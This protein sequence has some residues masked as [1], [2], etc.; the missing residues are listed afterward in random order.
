MTYGSGSPKPEAGPVIGLT[1]PILIVPLWV[2]EV[3]VRQAS[4]NPGAARPPR[5]RPVPLSMSRRVIAPGPNFLLLTCSS[6]SDQ[7]NAPCT[8]DRQFEPSRSKN[9]GLILFRVTLPSGPPP[10]SR[11]PQARR[12]RSG[13]AG[14][15]APC[16]DDRGLRESIIH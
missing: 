16:T 15:I 9:Q 11:P 3:E 13:R 8:D 5:T 7:V 6:Q 10:S 14:S 1:K 4:R 2:E 12:R